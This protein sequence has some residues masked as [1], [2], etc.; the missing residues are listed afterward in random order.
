VLKRFE[1]FI[2]GKFTPAASGRWLS[3][4]DPYAQTDWAEFPE[5]D[6]EDVDLAVAAA[7]RAFELTDWTRDIRSRVA[8]L[9]R[10]ADLVEA[11]AG[12]LAA[13]ES[14][15]NGKT[16]REERG[17][18]NGLPTY[19][20][21]AASYAET[22]VGAV[23]IG[24]RSDITSLTLR[25]PFGVIGIQT[26]WNSPC[27]LLVQA[28]APALAVG[29]TVV[30]KP[31]EIAPCS[32]L[33][34]ARLVEE[35]GFPPG[36]FNVVTGLGKAVGAALCAHPHVAKLVFTGS[37]EAGRV[38]AR[39]A[40]D[41]LVPLLM[42][43]G[44]KSANIVFPDADL[45]AAT[46][47]LVTGFT[48]SAGQTCVCGSRCLI[49][50]SIY[51]EFVA[52]MADLVGNFKI[53]DPSD[54]GTDI[55]PVCTSDQYARIERLV[56]SGREEGAVL[57]CGGG[58]PSNQ[59]DGLFFSPTIFAEATNQMTIAREEVFGPVTV[60]IRFSTEDEAVSMANDSPFGLAAGVWTREMSRAHRMARRLKAGTV[61][62][63][64]YRSGDATFPFGG[65]G[66]SGYGRVNGLDGMLEMSRIKSVQMLV[67]E[68]DV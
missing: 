35:A 21:L 40:A 30:A 24:A 20:R 45:N 3:S 56:A 61:W 50:D 23:P 65:T 4:T 54:V 12:K 43:L 18:Y 31:S 15:D 11:N 49:H 19:I 67:A 9:R 1:M 32:T 42:E 28:A 58:P 46:Q 14:R 64:Q 44:G 38:V 48:A 13:I 62:V 25:E 39:A 36:V 52:R 47:G 51:D 55:G 41:R 33:E 66:E 2:D 7:Q 16:I 22:M 27:F 6:E 17:M 34:L 60:C 5:G 37:P 53:G 26:P 10:L 63:N 57:V 8:L 59:A 68:G 29:N